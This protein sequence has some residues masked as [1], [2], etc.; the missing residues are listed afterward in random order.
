M[1]KKL[2]TILIATIFTI[3]LCASLVACDKTQDGVNYALDNDFVVK[4]TDGDDA[5]VFQPV[6]NVDA[7]G[8]G[9]DVP[10]SYGVI[11][12]V[13]MGV[14]PVKYQYLASALAKQG[15]LVVIPKI[16]NNLAYSN[17]TATEK[18]FEN[19]PNVRFF[20]AGHSH[21]GG[22]SAIRRA[23]ENT[24]AVAGAILLA[25]VGN[26]HKKL[27]E[28]GNPETDENGVE[29]YVS[30]TLVGTNL[31]ALLVEA[32]NDRVRTDEQVEDARA[33]LCDG[34]VARVVQNANHT[35]FAQID[36]E[37]DL[38]IKFL[39]NLSQDVNATTKEQ[40]QAQRTST[41][42]I[43]LAFLRSVMLG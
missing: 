31:S 2:L 30:D 19:Y 22:A 42:D 4:T 5:L 18:A 3:A 33:R 21:E 11:F 28:N 7:S 29:I 34:Y 38:P 1:K 12:Y 23:S 43:V 35:A 26:R 41:C 17:Y 37:D 14:E 40:K 39:P 25:P 13:G 15:Y 36:V 6:K 9:T 24:S 27:D 8:N 20:V 10:C 32:D 16:A